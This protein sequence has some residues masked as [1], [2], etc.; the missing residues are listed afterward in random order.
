VIELTN[1]CPQIQPHG[2]EVVTVADKV[3]NG[4]VW[5]IKKVLNYAS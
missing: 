1:P 4:E 2:I 5:V 3:A